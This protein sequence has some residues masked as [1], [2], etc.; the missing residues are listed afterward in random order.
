MSWGETL[1]LKSVIADK[2]QI[3]AV[4]NQ[5]LADI[6]RGSRIDIESTE[7][8][9]ATFTPKYSGW[10]KISYIG[11]EILSVTNSRIYVRDAENK[12]IA[13]AQPHASSA[14]T[15]Q[16]PFKVKLEKNKTYSISA[17]EMYFTEITILGKIVDPEWFNVVSEVEQQ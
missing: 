6:Y 3:L 14:A 7:T 11:K 17:V 1:Y 12:I 15:S 13:S 10:V 2:E 8:K 4:S 5:E 9:I 16:T